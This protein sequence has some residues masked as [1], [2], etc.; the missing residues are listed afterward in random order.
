M[1]KITDKDRLDFLQSQAWSVGMSFDRDVFGKFKCWVGGGH[2]GYGGTI[3]TAI[4]RAIRRTRREQ[5]K[6]TK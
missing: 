5:R 1:A 2:D 4:D 3:R 6:S